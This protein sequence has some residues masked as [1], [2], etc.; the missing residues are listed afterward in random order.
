MNISEEEKKQILSKYKDD[1]SDEILNYL[2]RHYTTTKT[3]LEWMP[4]PMLMININDKFYHVKGNKKF[5][6]GRLSSLL[7]PLFSN[8]DIKV[9]RR[10]IKK[11]LDGIFL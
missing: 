6:V 5:L 3:Y 11:Y 10:T 2:K 9:I 4:E 8:I 7:E 1:T